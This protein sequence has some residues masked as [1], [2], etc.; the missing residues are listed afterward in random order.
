MTSGAALPLYPRLA[1]YGFR[2]H[3]AYWAAAL[4]GAF[5]NSV[6][7]VLR[8]YV[9]IALWQARPGLGGTPSRTP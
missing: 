6:F 7:G 9:L 8:A 1:W 2:R 4:A 3:A 5:T